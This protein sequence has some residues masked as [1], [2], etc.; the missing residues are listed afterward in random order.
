MLDARGVPVASTSGSGATSPGPGTARAPTARSSPPARSSR[1]ASRRA[2]R[3]ARAPVPCSPRSASLP[4]VAAA[5][6]LS[7]APA[8]ISPDGD[9]ADDTLAIAY[10]LAAPAA[11]T[12][13]VIAPDGTTVATLVADVQLPA[14]GQSARW[15]GEGLA[16][17][18]ADGTY[19]VRLHVTDPA[20]RWPSAAAR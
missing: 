12:L 6:P 7:L 2:T 1:T 3:P 19:T 17:I 14:G 20:G 18:V 4:A 9:G 10:T 8:V 11:V 5:P 16:G 15:A 13:D